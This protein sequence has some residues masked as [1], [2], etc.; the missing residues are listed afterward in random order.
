MDFVLLGVIIG[1]ILILCLVRG[2]ALFSARTVARNVYRDGMNA[3]L[4]NRTN[5]P[6]VAGPLKSKFKVNVGRTETT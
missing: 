2:L 5:R 3:E 6:R 1:S 4:T